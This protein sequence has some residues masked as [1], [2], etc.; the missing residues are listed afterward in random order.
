M[1]NTLVSVFKN[2]LN[3]YGN[4]VNKNEFSNTE[5]GQPEVIKCIR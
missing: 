3:K 2:K 5:D 4:M 1:G